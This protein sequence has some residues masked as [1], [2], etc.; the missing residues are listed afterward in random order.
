MS[1]SALSVWLSP[2]WT[3]GSQ[4]SSLHNSYSVPRFELSTRQ[5]FLSERKLSRAER[6]IC[7]GIRSLQTDSWHTASAMTPIESTQTSITLGKGPD[8]GGK[9]RNHAHS[10][11][12]YCIH[13]FSSSSELWSGGPC[14]CYKYRSHGEGRKHHTIMQISSSVIMLALQLCNPQRLKDLMT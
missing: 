1:V 2:C 14:A 11:I 7:Y 12:W 13:Q 10:I 9:S 4:S 8:S 5:P 6:T 3:T